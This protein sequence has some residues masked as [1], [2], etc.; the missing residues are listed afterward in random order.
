MKDAHGI[1]RSMVKVGATLELLHDLSHDAHGRAAILV[2]P[3]GV[4]RPS[5]CGEKKALKGMP[6]RRDRTLL[7]LGGLGDQ[8]VPV[9]LGLRLDQRARGRAADLFIRVDNERYR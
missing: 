9:P 8:H 1:S 7:A 5:V 4:C 2:G 3:A 6:S